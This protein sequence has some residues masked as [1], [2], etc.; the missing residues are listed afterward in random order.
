MSGGPAR[1]SRAIQLAIEYAAASGAVLVASAGNNGDQVLDNFPAAYDAVICVGATTA[2]DGA[3][4]FSNH[5]MRIDLVAP[6][7]DILST[8]HGGYFTLSGTS[9]SAAYVSGVAAHLR[10]RHPELP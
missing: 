7:V 1:T 5:G 10:Y 2:T 4:S 6:G 3:A 9:Q 8:E